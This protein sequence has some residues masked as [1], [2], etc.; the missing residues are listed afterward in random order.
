MYKNLKK[1]A[2]ECLENGNYHNIFKIDPST[3]KL[4]EPG[5]KQN[6]IKEN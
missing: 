3:R 2:F 1:P 4:Q 5:N 6:K